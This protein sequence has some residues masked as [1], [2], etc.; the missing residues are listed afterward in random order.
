MLMADE[1]FLRKQQGW[2]PTPDKLH[3][4]CSLEADYTGIEEIAGKMTTFYAFPDGSALA[5]TND[6]F[7]AIGDWGEE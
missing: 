5:I 3:E 6:G 7:I 1:I 2:Y 4:R